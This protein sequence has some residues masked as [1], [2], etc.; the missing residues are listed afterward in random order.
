MNILKAIVVTA[1]F[2][3]LANA[4]EAWEIDLNKALVKA[5]AEN[6]HV[7]VNFTGSDWCDYCIKL[8]AEIFSQKAF[9]D[10]ATE[11][12]ILVKIDFPNKKKQSTA[13]KA[14]N[15][16]LLKKY[17]VRGFPTIKILNSEG[18]EIASTGYKQDSPEAYVKHLE[19][20]VTV[21]EEVKKAEVT[22]KN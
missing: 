13:L 9:K 6:K 22:E 7:F 16:Q 20:I 17:K 3:F 21:E 11:N 8:D 14:A 4:E 5:K 1:V 15:S 12:L 10:Y 19:S 18:I 2:A